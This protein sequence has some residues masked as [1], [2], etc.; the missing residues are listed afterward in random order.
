[1]S[2][3]RPI[4]VTNFKYV[5][6]GRPIDRVFLHCSASNNSDHD[7]AAVIDK[8]HRERGWAGIG[9]HFFIR[10]DGL[11]QT[12]R[13]LVKSPAA[14]RGHNKG[15]IAICLH[16]LHPGDFTDAQRATLQ[17][18]C[19]Q[20]RD[21]HM[22]GLIVREEP[23]LLAELQDPITFH[24]HTEVA[25]KDCPVFPYK[26]WL[27]L[28]SAGEMKLLR[29]GGA[30][31]GRGGIDY[32]DP[33]AREAV[34]RISELRRINAELRQIN[35]DRGASII[36]QNQEIDRLTKTLREKEAKLAR[37]HELFDD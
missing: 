1:M 34:D 30:R 9:Y 27:R 32:L 19:L 20:I 31:E 28:N 6:P 16:G 29:Q 3:G 2:V 4:Q 26:D 5:A 18:L 11:I 13:D 10:S 36:K 24:G 35:A 17:E 8:W 23:H 37:I 14:Q 33:C 7:D 22:D 12:G 21:A 25:N 15:T